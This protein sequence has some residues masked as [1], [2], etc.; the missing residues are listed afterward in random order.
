MKVDLA[1]LIERE[2]TLSLDIHLLKLEVMEKRKNRARVG[3]NLDSDPESSMADYTSWQN[4]NDNPEQNLYSLVHEKERIP[5]VNEICIVHDD[6]DTSVCSKS[7]KAPVAAGSGCVGGARDVLLSSTSAPPSSMETGSLFAN[8]LVASTD[9][10]PN[11][12]QSHVSEETASAEVI[13]ATPVRLNFNVSLMRK[14]ARTI[15]M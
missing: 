14:I 8:K 1:Y 3:D 7:Y 2:A 13:V 6:N 5:D 12:I 10:N 4:L 9:Q 11:E 15:Q